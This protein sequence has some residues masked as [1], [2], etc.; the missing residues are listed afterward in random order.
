MK[1]VKQARNPYALLLT[2]TDVDLHYSSGRFLAYHIMYIV[3]LPIKVI[4][5]QAPV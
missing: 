1:I 3:L 2:L 5:F 4:T